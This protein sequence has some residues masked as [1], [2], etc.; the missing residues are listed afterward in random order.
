L[1]FVLGGAYIGAKLGDKYIGVKEQ[2]MWNGHI[3]N[4]PSRPAVCIT[5][6]KW[7]GTIYYRLYIADAGDWALVG[8]S[9]QYPEI[10]A[11]IQNWERYLAEGGTL[12]A[13]R[14]HCRQREEEIAAMNASFA[15]ETPEPQPRQRK[16]YTIPGWVI[17]PDGVIDHEVP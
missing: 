7:R 1:L 8:Q 10:L 4:D 12:N 17:H 5:R 16:G 2:P 3:S 15:A 13:W 9:A 6:L 11:M 14:V